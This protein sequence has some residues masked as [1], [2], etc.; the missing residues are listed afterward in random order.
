MSLTSVERALLLKCRY[1]GRYDDL[2]NPHR[3]RGTKEEYAEEQKASRVKTPTYLFVEL[4]ERG[5]ITALPRPRLTDLGREALK[6]S[7]E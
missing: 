3:V 1:A 2:Q 5:L 6:E 7:G 4:A